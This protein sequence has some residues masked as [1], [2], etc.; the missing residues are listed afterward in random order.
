MDYKE[1]A[2]F[3]TEILKLGEKRDRQCMVGVE[4]E[5]IVVDKNSWNSIHYYQKDGIETILKKLMRFA[6]KPKFEGDSLIGLEHEDYIITLEPGGQLEISIRPCSSLKKIELIYFQFLQQVIP[7]LEEQNQF[8]MALG[9][10]PKSTI[11]DIP[12]IPKKRYQLMTAY[13]KEKGKYAHNM[14]K[15]TASLQISID[16]YDEEDF[17][18]KMRV[19]HFLSPVLAVISDNAPIFEGKDYEQNSLRSLIWQNTDPAR[20]GTIPGVMDQSFGYQEYADY[21]LNVEPI[22]F[23]K[24]D[25]ALSAGNRKISDLLDQYVF[26][27]PELEHLFSM[28]FPDARAKN[29]IEIRTG[30]SLPHPFSFSY[31]AFIKGLFYNQAAL[32]YLFQLT[33]TVDS[34]T[35]EKY[36]QS[37]IQKGLKGDFAS[38]TLIDFLPPLFDWAREGLPVEEIH[39]LQPLE[40]LILSQENVLHRTREKLDKEGLDGLR[41]CILNDLIQEECLSC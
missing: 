24:D 20:S 5:H 36:K 39:Y 11:A 18:K 3:L 27:V 17:I 10:H 37:M 32:D 31:I 8:L 13:L 4:I 40:N 1:K 29:Y 15:G 21:L 35:L 9:Y 25:R 22:L 6:Y 28:V 41:S 12:F 16:Y 23:L 19:A 34:E 7:I 14:K 30:D 2:H 38:K 26:T 33:E